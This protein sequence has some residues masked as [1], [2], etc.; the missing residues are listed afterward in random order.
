MASPL[1]SLAPGVP[2]VATPAVV[3]TPVSVSMSKVI[4]AGI[5]AAIMGFFVIMTVLWII[6]F[7]FRPTF[8]RYVVRGEPRPAED[9]GADPVR[10]F[11]ASLIGALIVV[12]IIWMISACR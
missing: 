8:V 9:A 4:G 10:C 12:V 5:G 1:S 11:I 3:G 2:I 7:S 6:L